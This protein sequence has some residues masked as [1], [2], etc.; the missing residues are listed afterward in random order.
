MLDKVILFPYYLTLKARHAIYDKG[1]KK[2]YKAEVPTICVGNI[3]VGGTGKTPHTEMILR[4]LLESEEWGMKNI[5]VLSRGYKRRSR[6][7]QQVTENSGAGFAGDEPA[8]LKKKFPVVTVAVCSNRVEGCH[9]LARPEDL[10][11]SKKGRRCRD[12]Q[13]RAAD[14]I[15]LD[16][17]FQY[18]K[19]RA[20]FNVVLIDYNRPVHKDSLIPLGDLRDLPERIKDADALIVT[21]CPAFMES[22]EKVNYLEAA[23][24]QYDPETCTATLQSG[25]KISVF[26][27]A[28]NYCPLK[29]VYPEK[30]D[31]RY[32]YSQRAILVTG[33][34]KSAPLRRYVGGQFKVVHHFRFSDH[35]RFSN[36]DIKA[37]MSAAESAPTAAVITTEK[38]AQRL[39]DKKIMP[40]SLKEKLFCIPI[41]ADFLSREEKELFVKLMLEKAKRQD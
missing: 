3:T 16:D 25:K 21:K 2:T 11:V 9:F 5:A 28:I 20:D 17:A 13:M 6:G 34:A 4:L 27:T 38:D 14:L 41:E 35:H 30:A 10:T 31:P 23:G 36:S 18:R 39:M 19:L 32:G 24:L 37:I 8:Q 15:V 26:F 22:W 7:F 29:P 40:D 33:I 1:L 12:K